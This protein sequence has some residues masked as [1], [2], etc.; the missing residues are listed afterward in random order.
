MVI[1]RTL[2]FIIGVIIWQSAFFEARDELSL[3]GELLQ[4]SDD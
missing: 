4:N 3:G 2:P 1:S